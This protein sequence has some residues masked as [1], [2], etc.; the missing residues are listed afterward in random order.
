MN[1]TARSADGPML[2]DRDFRRVQTHLYQH[3]G[4]HLSDVKKPL[5]ASRL[6]SRLKVTGCETYSEYIDKTLAEP[7]KPEHQALVDSLTTNETYF[8]REPDHFTFLEDLLKSHPS[9]RQ[10]RIWSGAASIGEEV[11]SLAMMLADHLGMKGSWEVVGTDINHKVISEAVLGHYPMSRHEGISNERLK[12]Y[13][14]KGVGPQQGT[15]LIDPELKQRVRFSIRNLMQPVRNDERYDVIFLRN[16]MI[17]FN[18]ESKQTVL[19][20]V[21]R[22]LKVGGYF[23]ISH[24]ESLMNVTHRLES[25]KPSVFRL[26]E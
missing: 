4:I 19:N 3:A 11:Y 1:H 16:V 12:R 25:I 14:L 17:Y 20:N 23:V 15:L 5:V 9:K 10:W 21:L 22:Q 6:L 8:F 7:T 26:P 2:S 13:C 18:N 24:T